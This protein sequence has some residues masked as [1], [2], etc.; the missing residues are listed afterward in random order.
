VFL[1]LKELNKRWEHARRQAAAW[2]RWN[3]KLPHNRVRWPIVRDDQGRRVGHGVPV[4]WPEPE[5]DPR[6]CRKIELPSGRVDLVLS[7]C[8]IEADYRQ[9]RYPKATEAEVTP[10]TMNEAE[11]R[12]W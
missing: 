10:L 8:E 12:R 3:R 7:G 1:L 4:P 5:L 11:I 2:K 9:A 6:F